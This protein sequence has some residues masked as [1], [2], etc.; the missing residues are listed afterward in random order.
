M[1]RLAIIAGTGIVVLAA[2]I[3][4]LVIMLPREEQAQIEPSSATDDR[5]FLALPEKPRTDDGKAFKP[6]WD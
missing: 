5:D 2:L 6:D 3:S 4:T 1:K